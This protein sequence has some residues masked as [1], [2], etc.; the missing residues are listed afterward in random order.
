MFTVLATGCGKQEENTD[1][2]AN[3]NANTVYEIPVDSI[4]NRDNDTKSEEVEEAD[5]VIIEEPVKFSYMNEIKNASPESGLIQIDDMLLQ[6]G[7]KFSDIASVIEQSECNYEAE[8][9]L[10]SVVLA[11]ET[12]GIRFYKDGK[13]YFIIGVENRESETI[14]LKDCI[15]YRILA[16]DASMGNVFYAGFNNDE[17]TYSTVKDAMGDYEPE[18]ETHGLNA[19]SN[20]ELGI[21]YE[22]PFQ[23]S[24]MYVYFIF[25]GISNKLLTIEVTVKKYED[26]V[27]WPW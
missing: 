18:K 3:D 25:D 20:R 16:A 6:Y 14:E 13:Q 21:R 15:T 10:S 4:I 17:M 2:Q 23:E 11:G 5:E 19:K 8:Y 1:V 26:D 12:L 7:A 9:N 27:F 24:N 22:I